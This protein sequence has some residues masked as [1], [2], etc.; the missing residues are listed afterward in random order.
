MAETRLLIATKAEL[1]F[2]TRVLW[3]AT[4]H[5]WWLVATTGKKWCSYPTTVELCFGT[6]LVWTAMEAAW[7]TL[8]WWWSATG[9][10]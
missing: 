7:T 8:D 4:E 2:G 10:H 6:G 1:Q 5:W 9:F 3:L